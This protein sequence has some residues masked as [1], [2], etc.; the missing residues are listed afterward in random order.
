MKQLRQ[1]NENAQ[2][3]EGLGYLRHWSVEDENTIKIYSFEPF[4][5]SIQALDFPILPRDVGYGLDIDATFPVGT[6][7]YMVTSWYPGEQVVLE[8]NPNWWQ[9]QP[10]IGKIVA[11]PYDDNGLAITALQLNQL[12]VVQTDEIALLATDQELNIFSYEYTTRYYE[13]MVPNIRTL[14]LEDKRVRQAIAHAL[15]RDEIVSNVY[16]NHAIPV[17]TPVPPTSF[18]YSGR[19]LTYNNDVEEAKNLLRL[20]GWKYLEDDDPWLDVSPDGWEM[21]FTLTLLTNNDSENPHR[22]EA[23]KYIAKQL[24]QV[25]IKVEVKSEDW[26]AYKNMV[27]EGRFDLLL[28]GWYLNDI[29]DL[30][31]AF[32]SGGSQ[33]LSGYMDAEMDELLQSVMEQSTREGLAGAFEVVQQKII[34]DLPIIS[35]YFRTHTLYTRRNIEKVVQVTEENA[36]SSIQYWKVK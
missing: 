18:L 1:Q 32:K 9:K 26:D 24:E 19:L 15:D 31:F 14:L 34:E 6:G 22:A 25:G 10:V 17:D 33:N 7:P 36:Y 2:F 16:I 13:F 27:R 3:C 35:L 29:P 12:D 30:R 28:G 21:D 4:Y 11:K 20:A 5:G 23:A 8:S